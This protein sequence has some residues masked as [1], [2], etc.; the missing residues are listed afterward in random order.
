MRLSRDRPIIC[1][2]TPG[3]AAPEN[4]A[5]YCS[6]L[7]DLIGPAVTAGVSLFQ[8]RE[9]KLTGKLLFEL[10]TSVVSAAKGTEIQVVVNDRLDIALAAEASGV[11][12]P[13]DSFD[14]REVRQVVPENFVIG[15]S[16]HNDR[17]LLHASEAGAD[18]AFFGPVYST[19]NKGAA[20]GLDGLRKAINA[21]PDLPILGLGGIT[22]TNYR[23]IIFT[24]AAGFAAIRSLNDPVQ[25]RLLAE[26]KI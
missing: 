3:N 21:V 12:L 9:K 14:A 23:E 17:E 26:T 2:I 19:P 7:I 8:L 15:V 1:L 25:L 10:V 18:Y 11:H 4:F 13:S 22:A 16:T 5:D 20:V 24:G 6:S